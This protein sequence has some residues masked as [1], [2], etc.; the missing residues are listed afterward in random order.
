MQ[1]IKEQLRVKNS[2]SN[3]EHRV[4][5]SIQVVICDSSEPE[6]DCANIELIDEF[7][8]DIYFTTYILQENIEFGDISNIG[9]RPVKANDKFHSQFVLNTKE[10]RDNNNFI[11]F[12]HVVTNDNY[13]DLISDKRKHFSFLQLNS[14]AFWTS[15]TYIKDELVTINGQTEEVQTTNNIVLGMYFFVS[16]N[17]VEHTR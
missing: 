13:L 14:N 1:A 3:K 10:Y 5:F 15:K 12:N 2:Y 6:D 16:D 17:I 4:S 8:D 9:K 7:L 11:Q